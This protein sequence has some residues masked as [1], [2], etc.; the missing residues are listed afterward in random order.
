MF[1]RRS[2]GPDEKIRV[3]SARLEALGDG[4]FAIVMTL[5]VLEL[6]IPE[7]EGEVSNQRIREYLHHLGPSLMSFGLSFAVLGILWFAHRM[8]HIFIGAVNRQLIW[9]NMLFYLFICL[10]PFSAAML[11]RYPDT[12]LV[13]ILYG[14]NLIFAIAFLY[15][16]WHYGTSL[17]G[18]RERDVPAELTREI[19]LLF[20]LAPLLYVLA[21]GLSFIVPRWGF[22]CYLLTPLLYLVPTRID[23]YLPGKEKGVQRDD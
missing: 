9:L 11:G 23:S 6:K 4:V 12:Q 10:I 13:V 5:L 7:W 16:I 21:I 20:G 1:A 8:E 15:W 3:G 17:P 2:K 22:Y 14:G 18:L 19:N